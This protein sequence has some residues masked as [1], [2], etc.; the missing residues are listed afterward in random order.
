MATPPSKEATSQLRAALSWPP[1]VRGVLVKRYKR[2]LADVCLD[3]GKA[4]TA[5]CANSG[6]MTS[7]CEAGRPVYLSTHDNPRRKLKYT[8]ELIDMASSLVGVNTGMPNRLVAAAL[9]ARAVPELAAYSEVTTEVTTR[10]GANGG[11]RLDIRL[12]GGGLPPCFVE[13][14]NCT[15]VTDG[16]ARFPDAVTTRGHK[17]LVELQRLV[18]E[19]ARGCMFYFVQ[20]MDAERFEP[21]GKIDPAYAAELARAVAGGVEVLVY[22]VKI[23]LQEIAL[24]RPLP[25]RISKRHTADGRPPAVA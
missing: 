14:K 15:L 16:V 7:C 25:C 13:V 1:L 11:S 5:H 22:D 17:H 24:R 18:A 2:F 23:D 8:W 6:R 9:K 4:V 10:V 20:R 3:N 19:G 21:A 12:D